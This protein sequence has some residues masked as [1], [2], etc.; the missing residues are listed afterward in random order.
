MAFQRARW[1]LREGVRA[2]MLRLPD[3]HLILRTYRLVRRVPLVGK[4]WRALGGDDAWRNVERYVA[5]GGVFA[6]SDAG[7]S[8]APK[9]AFGEEAYFLDL[10]DRIQASQAQHQAEPG[11]IVLV[12]NGLSAGGAERQIVYTLTGLKSRGH[13]VRF[14]GEFM[15]RAPG[16]DFHAASLI[17]AGVAIEAFP[18]EAGPGPSLYSSVTRPVA[19]SLAAAPGGFM[20]QVLDMVSAF[21]RLRPDVVH[22]WQD[23]TSTKYGFAALIAGVPNIVLSGR[24]LNPTHFEFHQPFMR[25]AYRALLSAPGVTLSNNTQ[26]GANSY[27]Q[28][29]GIETKSIRVIYNGFDFSRFGKSGSSARTIT[30]EKYGIDSSERLILGV[31]RLSP[32]KRPELWIRTAVAA[33]EQDPRLVFLIA[34]TGSM[35]TEL[36]ARVLASGYSSRI[37]ILGEISD[38]GSLYAA[39]DLFF[40]ASSEEGAP[41]VLI[42]AQW[43]GLPCVVTDAGGVA[44]TVQNGVTAIVVQEADADNLASTLLGALEDKELTQRARDTGPGFVTGRFSAVRMVDETIEAYGVAAS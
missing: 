28:W 4:V 19:E 12:N 39:A 8:R 14:I 3:D 38:V 11:R 10:I 33:L 20:L 40:L 42:E 16:L 17:D 32:E 15:G 31:F 36:R 30:R 6:A 2:L 24:N 9:H 13:D 34:G 7:D 44:E 25:S 26:A 43:A 41:N 35:E 22:L 21:K 37:R 29:L 27:G 5:E 23:E 18:R 1:R